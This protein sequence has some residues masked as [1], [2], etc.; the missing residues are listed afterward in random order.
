[1]IDR[2]LKL[3]PGEVT[4][5]YTALL[6]F[7]ETASDATAKWAQLVAIAICTALIVI[8]IR[9]DARA[10]VPP[11]TPHVLQYVI[12]I[13]AF[14]AWTFVIRNPL[15]GFGVAV[16]TWIPGFAIVLIPIFGSLLFGEEPPRREERG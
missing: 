12:S 6:A 1:V 11:V 9:R 10:R 15:A 7:A 16:P 14:W 8:L 3:I 2:A 4:A 5:G 13:L